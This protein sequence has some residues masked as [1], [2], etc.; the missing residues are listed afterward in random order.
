[1][2]L[3]VDNTVATPILLQPIDYGADIV[4]HSLTKFMGGH[5]TTLGGAIVDGGRFRLARTTR[6]ATRSSPSRTNPITAS[7]TPSTYGAAALLARCRSVY[8]RTTGAVLAPINAFLLLQGIE[9]VA[10]AHR[11]PRRECAARS[12]SICAVDPRV[13]SVNYAGFPTAPI[14]RWCKN[15][16]AGAPARC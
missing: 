11:A 2:P 4:V 6:R 8:Q 3:I 10:A 15:T 13:E 5:G 14:T 7:S 9:T 16:W 12:P 1:M